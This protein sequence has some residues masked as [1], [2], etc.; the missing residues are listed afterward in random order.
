MSFHYDEGLIT[1]VVDG[2]VLAKIE[3][4]ANKDGSIW[5]ITHTFVDPTLRGQ[6]IAN[7]LLAEVM[8]LAKEQDKRV[9][10]TCPFAIK[11]FSV[12]PEYQAL[13]VK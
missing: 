7:R 3:F 9:K 6:G 8:R 11:M 12:T 5:D 13:E 1:Y 4:P 2:E 10:A